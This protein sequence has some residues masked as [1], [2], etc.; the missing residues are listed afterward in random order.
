VS[1]AVA[2]SGISAVCMVATVLLGAA[3]WRLARA[4]AGSARMRAVLA[5]IADLQEQLRVLRGGPRPG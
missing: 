5:D 4:E 1:A 3:G 2:F